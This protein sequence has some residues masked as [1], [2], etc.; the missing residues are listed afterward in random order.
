MFSQ[1]ESLVAY[2][3]FQVQKNFSRKINKNFDISFDKECKVLSFIKCIFYYKKLGDFLFLF[4]CLFC[5]VVKCVT[6]DTI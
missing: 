3:S 6:V 1:E 2:K 5:A 4:I